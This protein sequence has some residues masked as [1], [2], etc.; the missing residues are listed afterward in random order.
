MKAS[1]AVLAFFLVAPRAGAWVAIVTQED[2][3]ARVTSLLAQ[4]RGLQYY[5]RRLR[6]K[7]E[8]SLLAQERGL[9]YRGGRRNSQGQGVAPRAG[10][11]VA[12]SL[13]TRVMMYP[14]RSSRRS[15]GCNIG[16]VLGYK[17]AQASLLAQERGLQ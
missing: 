7:V 2:N 3:A 15:V 10:A 1:I 5:D 16:T 8:G 13:M 17:L 14:R 9:Q 6:S 4:E 11:W 12:I